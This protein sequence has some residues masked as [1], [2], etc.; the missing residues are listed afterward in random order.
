MAA[1]DTD[2][3]VRLARARDRDGL[4]HLLAVED[5]RY[6]YHLADSPY[7][8][9]IAEAREELDGARWDGAFDDDPLW[10]LTEACPHPVADCYGYC[11]ACG[12]STV[13]AS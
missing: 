3:I 12:A 13:E 2:T 11:E 10:V 1:F 6:R 5:G 8:R 7:V 9:T 4:R